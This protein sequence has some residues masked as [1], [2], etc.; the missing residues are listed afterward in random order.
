MRCVPFDR[1]YVHGVLQVK[2]YLEDIIDEPLTE[3]FELCIVL[4]EACLIVIELALT[5][6]AV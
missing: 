2:A 4:S 3:V 6:N 1:F 5:L